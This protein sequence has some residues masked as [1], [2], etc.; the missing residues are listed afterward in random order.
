MSGS[1]RLRIGAGLYGEALLAKAHETD[2]DLLALGS[3]TRIMLAHGD[4][5]PLMRY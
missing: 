5:P 4:L 3:V 2:A 1:A